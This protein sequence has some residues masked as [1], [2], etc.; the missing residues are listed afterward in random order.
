M[1]P[2]T[3]TN[4]EELAADPWEAAYLRFETPEEEE[5]K[6]VRRLV[7]VG[8]EDWN[9]DSIIVDLFCGRGGGARALRR[10]GFPHVVGMDLS[11]RLLRA[12]ADASDCSVADCRELPIAT[13]SADI[14]VVQGGL[15]HLPSIPEDLSAVLREV[16]RAL[17]PG[18]LF[19]VV[20][21]WSTPFLNLVHWACEQPL[22]RKALRK[23]DALA[24]MIEY[25]RDTY[26]AWLRN[27]P[28]ILAELGRHFERRQLRTSLGKLH[29]VGTPRPA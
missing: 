20:E 22:A 17:R 27:G 13:G 2:V 15:H 11:P 12:R 5:R 14:A 7:A 1:T 21:P 25:E 24:T 9:R 18:G 8:A 16:A 4:G 10:L 19:V 28:V 23:L 6:F 3:S 26:E 29:F